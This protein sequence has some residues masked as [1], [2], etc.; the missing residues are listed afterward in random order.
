M[1]RSKHIS[2]EV[3]ELKADYKSLIQ[4]ILALIQS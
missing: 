2:N 1:E 3:G 4:Y